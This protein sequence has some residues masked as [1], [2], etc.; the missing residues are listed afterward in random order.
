MAACVGLECF[1]I[2]LREAG[3][4]LVLLWL[5]TLSIVYGMLAHAS[6]PKSATARGVISITVAF[7]VLLAAAATP[8]VAF[9]QNLI[10]AS[11]VIAFGLLTVVIFLEISGAKKGEGGHLISEHP[12]IF[13][14]MIVL[15]L[16]LVFVGTGGLNVVNVPAIDITSTIGGIILFLAVMLVAIYILVKEGG[17]K[18]T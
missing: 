16:V 14:G 18:K 12:R 6:I 1:I 3:F 15:L 11:I 17:T 10:T 5:L 4:T 13:G 2:S 7:L 9:L 8:A